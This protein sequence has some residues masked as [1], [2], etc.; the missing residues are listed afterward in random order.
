MTRSFQNPFHKTGNLHA[1]VALIGLLSDVVRE[2]HK[3]TALPLSAMVREALWM[4]AEARH[5]VVVQRVVTERRRLLAS[6]EPSLLS[7]S[8][9]AG[10]L[11]PQISAIGRALRRKTLERGPLGDEG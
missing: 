4:W 10:S 6:R 2:L 5:P 11:A 8:E 3:E 7:A 1:R 9:L